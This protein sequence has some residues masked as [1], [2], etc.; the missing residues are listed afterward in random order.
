MKLKTSVLRIRYQLKNISRDKMCILTFLL[1]IAAAAAVRL[2]AGFDFSAVTENAFGIVRDDLQEETV[3]WLLTY[4]NVKEFAEAEELEAAVLEPSTPLIGVLAD[5][6]GIR[7]LLA[8][9]ELEINRVVGDTLPV[10]YSAGI[11]VEEHQTVVVPK[12]K[13]GNQLKSLLAAITMVTAMFMGCTFNAMNII[14]EKEEG[15]AEVNKVIPWTSGG[16]VLQK[17]VLGFLGGSLSAAAAALICMRTEP[18]Q[19][20]VLF[21]FIILSGFL[22]A[23][24][25]LFIGKLSGGMMTGIVYIKIVMILFLAPPI[26]VYLTVPK[27]SVLY[28][29]SLLL[30]S[31][32]VFYGL[33]DLQNTAGEGVIVNLVVLAVH[34]IWW[35]SLYLFWHKRRQSKMPC[36]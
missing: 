15:I 35:L 1:P 18:S 28:S 21:L 9:D 19:T 11:S 6:T 20:A 12:K 24:T 2:L 32:S 5:G 22:A 17:S 3:E 30:P 4:G 8:G 13:N 29:L 7:T 16:Y 27:G 10:L 31:G 33:M 34:C 14:S 36:L 23:L 25:G 26:L